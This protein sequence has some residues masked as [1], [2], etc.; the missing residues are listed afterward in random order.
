MEEQKVVNVAE[1]N[2]TTFACTGITIA[3]IYFVSTQC[4]PVL[5]N[6]VRTILDV[7][8]DQ[9]NRITSVQGRKLQR[10]RLM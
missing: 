3:V 6:N 7:N 10:S 5:P 9:M 2:R 4:P 8:T 1:I